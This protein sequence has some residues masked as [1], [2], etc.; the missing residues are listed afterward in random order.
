MNEL[1]IDESIPPYSS[2]GVHKDPHVREIEYKKKRDEIMEKLT[3]IANSKDKQSVEDWQNEQIFALPFAKSLFYYRRTNATKDKG[4]SEEQKKDM[5]EKWNIETRYKRELD[6]F[7]EVARYSPIRNL[8]ECTQLNC[9]L[10]RCAFPRV[11]QLF[12]QTTLD[13]VKDIFIPT[14]TASLQQA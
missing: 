11:R 13:E 12:E 4:N 14:S 3:H 8:K 7:R 2:L 10:N 9:P 5:E 1:N 6:Y